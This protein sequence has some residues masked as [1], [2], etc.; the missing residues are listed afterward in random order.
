MRPT[1]LDF[2]YLRDAS[3]AVLVRA[4]REHHW[5]Q[6]SESQSSKE[7]VESV[8]GTSH[9]FQVKARNILNVCVCRS[10]RAFG[11]DLKGNPVLYEKLFINF[12]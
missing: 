12:S 9:V 5:F 8:R 7:I 10:E 1:V 6:T 4:V 2:L 3:F 11:K